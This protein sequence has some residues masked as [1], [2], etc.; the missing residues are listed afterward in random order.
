M[1]VGKKGRHK[2]ASKTLCEDGI[3]DTKMKVL[4]SKVCHLLMDI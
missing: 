3:L 1:E 4:R 2:K